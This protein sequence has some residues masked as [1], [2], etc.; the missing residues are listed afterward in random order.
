MAVSAESTPESPENHP[1]TLYGGFKTNPEARRVVS[2][3][4]QIVY[5]QPLPP[6]GSCGCPAARLSSK[7]ATHG[8]VQR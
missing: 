8:R 4:Q 1:T 7:Q 3:V 2:G 6:W 5:E